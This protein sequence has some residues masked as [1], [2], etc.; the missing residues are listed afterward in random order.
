M[1]PQEIN[2]SVATKSSDASLNPAKDSPV[3]LSPKTDELSN[4]TVAVLDSDSFRP[5][6][7]QFSLPSP[8]N[9]VSTSPITLQCMELPSDILVALKDR[10]R[11]MEDLAIVNKDFFELIRCYLDEDEVWEKFVTLLYTPREVLPDGEWMDA[12][13]KYLRP[14]RPLFERFREMVGYDLETDLSD[15]EN[16]EEQEAV[17]HADEGE[18]D[19]DD[20]DG[21]GYGRDAGIRQIR[22]Y[23]EKLASFEETYPK[24]FDNLRRFL[25]YECRR[26]MYNTER[27]SSSASLISPTSP[28]F[29]SHISASYKRDTSR[30]NSPPSPATNIHSRQFPDYDSDDNDNT[31]ESLVNHLIS[32]QITEQAIED[33]DLYN[34]FLD[35][36]FT[37]R[38][39]MN[40]DEWENAVYDILSD[41][42]DLLS[43][44][45]DI[46]K[47][48]IDMQGDYVELVGYEKGIIE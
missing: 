25:S 22:D 45:E 44:L 4:I 6:T 9:T 12:V 10:K 26:G 16:D 5:Q 43:E 35:I 34:R 19:R 1:T 17:D 31:P 41:C 8:T 21:Y 2:T 40:D 18:D 36:F 46:V 28:S 3:N 30:S 48:D 27:R 13:A 42:P 15:P 37:S 38:R 20:D 39:L 14:N 33:T 29:A 23:P 32:S 47:Y 11:E 24:F 7:V